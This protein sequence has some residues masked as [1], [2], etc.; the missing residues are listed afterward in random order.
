MDFIDVADSSLR[1][2]EG[3]LKQFFVW[4]KKNDIHQPTRRDI[5]NFRD[6]IRETLKPTTVQNYIVAIHQFFKWTEAEGIYP[7]IAKNVKGAR[8]SKEH[9]K[10]ALTK[11][12]ARKVLDCI[13]R[14]TLVGKRDY[15]ILALMLTCGL[16]DVE[17]IRANI[18]DMRPV[19]D[20][21]AIFVQGK[22]RDERTEY[23]R[24]HQQT[25]DA[26]REYLMERGAVDEREP[27][28]TSTSNRNSNGRMRTESLSRIVKTRL[29]QAGFNSSRITAHSLRH[30]SITLS[31]LG[32]KSI[33]ETQEFA[34]HRDIT[35]TIV[36]DHS[37]NRAKN[38][39]G[40]AV[41]KAIFESE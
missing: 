17:V 22:G 24:I 28:F 3:W 25:E 41:S 12:Q 40:E 31:L 23:V 16:R 11:T 9:K 34:R 14:S 2:Y 37:L 26:I 38:S 36:Y 6:E 21:T 18:D 32:G 27:L 33:R 7:D 35:T 13:D 29:R 1:A 4:M 10:D 39:C 8:V 20:F 5:L 19:A 15:A 30:T